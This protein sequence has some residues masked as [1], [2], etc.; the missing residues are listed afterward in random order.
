LF[1]FTD[2]AATLIRSLISSAELSPMSGLRFTR[3]GR[4][5]SLEMSLADQPSD[6]DQ[7]FTHH[8]TRVFV[9]PVAALRL[10]WQVL[11]ARA[12]TRGASFLL[13]DH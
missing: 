8:D 13:I 5:G 2:T 4:S 12:D 10:E 11:D 1:T 9:A 6:G 3:N 7:V